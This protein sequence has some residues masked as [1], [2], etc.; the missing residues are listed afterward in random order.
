[1]MFLD[2]VYLKPWPLGDGYIGRGGF[3]TVSKGLYCGTP[4]AVKTILKNDTL[5]LKKEIKML[6]GL[7]HPNIVSMITHSDSQIVM[8]LYDG[9]A[10]K[11]ASLDELSIVGRDCMRA[12]VFMQIHSAC[13]SHGDIKPDNILLDLDHQTGAIK[14]AY[15]GDVG[16]ARVCKVHE[17]FSGTPGFMPFPEP[18]VHGVF[19]VFALAVSLLDAFFVERVRAYFPNMYEGNTSEFAQKLPTDLST[20]IHEMLAVHQFTKVSN[21]PDMRVR[22]LLHMLAKWEHLAYKYKYSK[23]TSRGDSIEQFIS[24]SKEKGT[25]IYS[26]DPSSVNDDPSSVISEQQY[27]SRPDSNAPR[28][29]PTFVPSMKAPFWK[30]WE[31]NKKEETFEPESVEE[32]DQERNA[33]EF[34]RLIGNRNVQY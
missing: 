16:L 22:W 32:G 29:E 8:N 23:E 33:R 5:A 13:I 20:T 11:I 9:N 27:L 26:A 28:Y 2:I 34:V 17:G 15:L 12:I 21:D 6:Q 19:D 30:F 1:M 31:R 25:T 18:Y 14:K 3:G 24:E 7:R 4:V 10:S